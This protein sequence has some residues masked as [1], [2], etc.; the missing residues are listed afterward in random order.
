MLSTSEWFCALVFRCASYK[1]NDYECRCYYDR[2]SGEKVRAE[3]IVNDKIFFV[4][5]YGDS[6]DLNSDCIDL[7][8]DNIKLDVDY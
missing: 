3:G 5:D 1:T 4:N 7:I 6:I 8:P 2:V